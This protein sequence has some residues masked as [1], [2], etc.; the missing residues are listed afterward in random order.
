MWRNQKPPIL[1]Q[2]QEGEQGI[3]LINLDMRQRCLNV[4]DQ[5]VMGEHHP[6][7]IARRA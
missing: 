1:T 3:I 2:G 7:G 4:G 5:I 6:L